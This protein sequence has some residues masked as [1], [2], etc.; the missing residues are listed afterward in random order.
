MT[1]KVPIIVVLGIDVDGRAH[2]S[3]FEERDAPFVERAAELMAF[4]LIRVPPD[5]AELHAIAEGL[6]LGKIFATG[7][8]FVPYVGRA[9]FDKLATLVEGDITARAPRPMGSTPTEPDVAS[10]ADAECQTARNRDPGSASNRDPSRGLSQACP[11]SEQEGPARS[12][13]TATSP[14]ER[15][16]GGACLPTS[17]AGG[18][19]G[20]QV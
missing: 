7:R 5:N 20:V 12:G 13:V 17:R 6:P 19:T 10:S 15:S 8:A 4:Q 1:E 9:A 16:A 18:S 14:T 11:G 2:A 3:R